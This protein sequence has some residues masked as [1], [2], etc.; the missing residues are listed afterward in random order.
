MPGT[1]FCG[2]GVIFNFFFLVLF[3]CFSVSS[4]DSYSYGS[5]VVVKVRKVIDGDTFRCDLQGLPDIIGKNISVR[6]ADIDAPELRGT[7]GDIKKNAEM[8]RKELKRIILS[9]D[10]IILKRMKRGKFF[11]IV[12]DVCIDGKDVGNH[13]VNMGLAVS[14]IYEN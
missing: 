9:G 3:S 1:F 14:R 7:R 13:L 5:A 6:I 8:A 12:A 4:A 11:R 10:S 2:S